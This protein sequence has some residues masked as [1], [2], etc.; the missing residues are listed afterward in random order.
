MTVQFSRPTDSGHEGSRADR[1]R[2]L[3]RRS[4]ILD[5][6]LREARPL[7]APPPRTF[8]RTLYRPGE[9][10]QF[11]VLRRED[12]CE[13][14]GRLVADIVP[15]PWAD[16][17]RRGDDLVQ[18]AELLAAG[19]RVAA[20]E[21]SV[22]A[23]AGQAGAFCRRRPRAA[24]CTT[25]DELVAPGAVLPRD[26]VVESNLA[27]LSAQAR[28]A[29]AVPCTSAHAADTR[30]GTVDVLAAL[31]HERP[32]LLIT[33]GGISV[34]AHDHVGP[35]LGELGARWNLRG[36]AMRP[37]HPVGIALCGA[38]VVLALPGNP[39]AAAVCFHV[40]GRALL[41]VGDDWQGTAL[42]AAP[43]ARHSRDTTFLRCARD[44]DALRPLERQG[45]AQ[46]TS[47]AGAR[48]LASIAP[49]K[50]AVAAGDRV[51]ASSMP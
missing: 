13:A 35:A 44:G 3:R 20:H 7:F 14:G 51:S 22:V 15:R 36:V 46:P 42:L 17:R 37:G 40:L 43:V 38:T 8:Q 28:A 31:I 23:A 32:D 25:G 5:V 24:F 1:R 39:A 48:A 21:A 47:L 29:G 33:V 26:G 6:Y 18:G 45:A 10:C 4:T 41:G 34:G 12:G 2:R 11:D 16:V 27:G 49:G 9:I 30:H 19:T 50:G